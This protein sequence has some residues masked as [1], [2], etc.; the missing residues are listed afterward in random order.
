MA[1][2]TLTLTYIFFFLL[3]W[4]DTWRI[5]IGLVIGGVVAPVLNKADDTVFTRIMLFIM[6]AAIGYA[7]S[8]R[9]AQFISAKLR[10]FILKQG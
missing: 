8:A 6:P 2:R 10:Q 4:P 1:K 9:P 7:A 5:L 3:F